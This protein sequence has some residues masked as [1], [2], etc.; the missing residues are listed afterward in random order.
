MHSRRV[1][2]V[3]LRTDQTTRRTSSCYSGL[4]VLASCPLNTRRPDASVPVNDAELGWPPVAPGGRRVGVGGPTGTKGEPAPTSETSG[5]LRSRPQGVVGSPVLRMSRGVSEPVSKSNPDLS[6]GVWRGAGWIPY[7]RLPSIIVLPRLE[8]FEVIGKRGGQFG[9][10][11]WFDRIKRI[12][13][14]AC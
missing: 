9:S 4:P 3:S 12:L 1:A 10:S 6:S 14:L 5:K 7:Y 2:T 11:E 8:S 13:L